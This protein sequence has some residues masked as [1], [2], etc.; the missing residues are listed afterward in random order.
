MDKHL[1][2][3]AYDCDSGKSDGRWEVWGHKPE[4][5]YQ[6]GGRCYSWLSDSNC[7][8]SRPSC[9][10]Y[11][12]VMS[13]TGFSVEDIE[14]VQHLED[15]IEA[16]VAY[17]KDKGYV[18]DIGKV[19]WKRA[20]P[21]EVQF[22]PDRE[23]RKGRLPGQADDPNHP[24]C[25]LCAAI[26]SKVPEFIGRSDYC[27]FPNPYPIFRNHFT[28]I[29]R[30]HEDSGQIL[31]AERI[32]NGIDFFSEARGIKMFFNGKNAG[33]SSPDHF[34]FQGFSHPTPLPVERLPTKEI[35]SN[36]SIRVSKP[37]DYP[38]TVFVV[39]SEDREKLTESVYGI[40]SLLSGPRNGMELT[41]NVL[42]SDCA[43]SPKAYIFPR[44]AGKQKS[45]SYKSK[46]ASIEM[47]GILVMSDHD[48]IERYRDADM[49]ILEHL[50]EDVLRDV[51][52]PMEK[53][54]PLLKDLF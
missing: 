32:K 39:E 2:H 31:T 26:H 48:D 25:V 23:K 30:E 7:Q 4:I 15:K 45:E 53:L 6:P 52:V 49:D 14:S 43:W 13:V 1:V 21:F 17:N 27:L 29:Y 51:T 28:L 22:N 34:H 46:P 40:T 9:S 18:M 19:L 37:A 20:G 54:S 35:V 38:A 10:C 11:L 33:A 42:F 36:K 12:E 16:L 47:S 41:H 24:G 44:N 50:A 3:L 8:T 5:G